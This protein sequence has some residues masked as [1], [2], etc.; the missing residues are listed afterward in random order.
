MN[1][2]AIE[3]FIKRLIRSHESVFRQ[4]NDNQPA[5]LE[6]AVFLGVKEHYRAYHYDTEIRNP[7]T[8][9]FVVKTRTQ[10]HPAKY[11]HLFLSNDGKEFEAHMN[12]AVRSAHDQGIYCVDVGI[13]KAGVLPR[14]ISKKDKWICLPNRELITFVETK[15]LPVYPMLLAQ[16]IGIVHEI[17]PSFVSRRWKQIHPDGIHFHPALVTLGH[18]SG[19]SSSIISKYPSRNIRVTIV[20]NYDT[21]LAIIRRGSVTSPFANN[22]FEVETPCTPPREIIENADTAT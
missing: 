21:R 2:V 10:G 17:M 9:G 11:S 16:F 4:I 15:K 6:L 13:A 18:L 14:K 7:K 3:S 20:T 5:L 8:G 1:S 12:L 19:N 22:F